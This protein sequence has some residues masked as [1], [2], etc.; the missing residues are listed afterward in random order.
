MPY[1]AQNVQFLT[2][3]HVLLENTT[4]LS[5]KSCQIVAVAYLQTKLNA[6]KHWFMVFAHL[7]RHQFCGNSNLSKRLYFI[8][9][10]PQNSITFQSH[11]QFRTQFRTTVQGCQI[12]K[13][14]LA[15]WS[16]KTSPKISYLKYATTDLYNTCFI[17]IFTL[18]TVFN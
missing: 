3:V 11:R 16:V 12:F 13:I 8:N 2:F 6:I 18:Y 14:I 1:N 17:S 5:E 9:V 10:W 7:W 4:S 15:Q